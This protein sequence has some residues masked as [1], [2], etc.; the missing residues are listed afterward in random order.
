MRQFDIHPNPSDRSRRFAPFV[1]VLQSHL[2]AAAPT[3][4]VAPM[5]LD[6]AKSAY[7][8]TSTCVLFAGE[9]Y[10]VAVAELAA[11]EARHLERAV[12]D[13]R[14]HEDAIRRALDRL[15]TDF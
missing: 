5:I 6:D 8:Q 15:F 13:L 7:T 4:V 11:I 3:V 10:I 14:D 1:V 9:S 2:L 12:G